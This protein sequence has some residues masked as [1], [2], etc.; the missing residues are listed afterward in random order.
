MPPQD[1]ME[2]NDD[3]I[4][5]NAMVGVI[6][7]NNT[8]GRSIP[9][10]INK[11]QTFILDSNLAKEQKGQEQF[12][13]AVTSKVEFKLEHKNEYFQGTIAG[14]DFKV[15][16]RLKTGFFR[17][18]A[19]LNLRRQNTRQAWLALAT[20]IREHYLCGHRCLLLIH[21]RGLN[22]PGSYGILRERVQSWLI[23]DPLKRVVLAFCTA[24]PRHGSTGAIYILLRKYKKLTPPQLDRCTASLKQNSDYKI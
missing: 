1:A 7:M 6:P 14:L 22:S 12:L 15:L 4:F 10:T 2:T 17:P 23:N 3:A 24:L 13:N 16:H 21:G 8:K 19:H 18:E 5:S 20:F 9:Q 11:L